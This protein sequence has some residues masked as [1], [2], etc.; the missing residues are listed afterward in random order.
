MS[1][2]FWETEIER[3]SEFLRI[4]EADLVAENDQQ[5]VPPGLSKL[6]MPDPRH[7]E[8]VLDAVRSA[9]KVLKTIHPK[10]LLDWA[11]AWQ[12]DERSWRQLWTRS[13]AAREEEPEPRAWSI[14]R[15]E[16][17]IKG[18]LDEM[19]LAAR[20]EYLWP[21]SLPISRDGGSGPVPV[22][23]AASAQR[24]VMSHS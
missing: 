19:G 18:M 17:R 6:E 13:A 16:N 7:P 14:D 4:L 22:A 24:R 23:P 9:S 21:T 20:V 3:R 15:V 10:D 5:P 12:A 8:Q 1:L 2:T 11:A